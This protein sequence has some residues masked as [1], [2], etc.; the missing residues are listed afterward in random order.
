[1]DKPVFVIFNNQYTFHVREEGNVFLCLCTVSSRTIE[2]D[3][4]LLHQSEHL[5]LAL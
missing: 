1:M 2:R 4:N 3:K 5:Y